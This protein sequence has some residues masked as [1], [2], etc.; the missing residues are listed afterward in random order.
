MRRQ[1]LQDDKRVVKRIGSDLEIQ[2][3][4]KEEVF[5]SDIESSL[6]MGRGLKVNIDQSHCQRVIVKLKAKNTKVIASLHQTGIRRVQF[7]THEIGIQ[8]VCIIR[9]DKVSIDIISGVF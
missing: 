4:I 6:E 9:S 8:P 1:L 2:S 3:G 5:L 7:Y